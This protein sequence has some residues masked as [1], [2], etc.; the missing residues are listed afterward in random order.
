[1][2]GLCEGGNEPP[3]SLKAMVNG[4][5][6]SNDRPGRKALLE[7]CERLQR[8]DHFYLNSSA[9]K[10]PHY[11]ALSATGILAAASRC[12]PQ[13]TPALKGFAYSLLTGPI[14][15]VP[16]FLARIHEK[17][18]S[19]STC[20][21]FSRERYHPTLTASKARYLRFAFLGCILEYTVQSVACCHFG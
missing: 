10:M 12:S 5:D 14:Q 17:K 19:V 9:V 6:Q 1:M 3:G 2:A 15:P 4:G 13:Q 7:G 11:L 20:C 16:A 18:Q 8:G 21:Q